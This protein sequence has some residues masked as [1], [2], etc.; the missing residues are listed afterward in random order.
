VNE[1]TGRA[2]RPIGRGGILTIFGNSDN[3][4]PADSGVRDYG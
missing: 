1:W 4:D 2:G 3:P